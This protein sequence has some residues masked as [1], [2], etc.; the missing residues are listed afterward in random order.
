[1][2]TTQGGRRGKG[3]VICFAAGNYNLPTFLSATDNSRGLEYYGPTGK[4]L[5]H[6]FKNKEV[7]SGWPELD[8][9]IVVGSVTHRFRKSLYSNWG[10][11]LSVVAPSDNWHPRS[12]S[13]RNQYGSKNIVTTD[14]DKSGLSLN[15]VGLSSQDLGQV[16]KDMGGTS[17]ATPMIAGI[18]ALIL[19]LNEQLTAIEVRQILQLSA[20][21][22]KIDYHLDDTMYNNY[23]GNGTFDVNGQSLWFGYGLADAYEALKHSP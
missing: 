23:N 4:V 8:N 9:V 7:H 22:T 11:H 19:S 18:C 20:N 17:A 2:L 3:L 21:K 14:N 5:G 12:S 15:E 1:V 13:T 6:F 16:T 10:P